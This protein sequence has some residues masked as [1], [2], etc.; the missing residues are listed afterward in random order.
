MTNV[1][2]ELLYETLKS[3]QAT[4]ADHSRLHADHARSFDRMEREVRAFR[5]IGSGLIEHDV[6]QG[7]AIDDLRARVARL[8]ERLEVT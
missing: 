5:R 4:L 2:N 7:D 6:A 8:E 1:S 3:I